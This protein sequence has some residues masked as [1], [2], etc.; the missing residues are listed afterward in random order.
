MQTNSIDPISHKEEYSEVIILSKPER[1][2][3]NVSLKAPVFK[4]RL[5]IT[6]GSSDIK[7]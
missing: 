1:I 3:N 5:F 7:E 6:I 2:D 4:H